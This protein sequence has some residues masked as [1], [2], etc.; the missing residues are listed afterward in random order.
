MRAAVLYDWQESV[1]MFADD[2]DDGGAGKWWHL[3]PTP[4][5]AKMLDWYVRHFPSEAYGTIGEIQ[6]QAHT[7]W[8]VPAADALRCAP[9]STA[10]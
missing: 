8:D 1:D 10:S 4:S 7:K 5:V 3:N 6:Q 9:P 2:Q